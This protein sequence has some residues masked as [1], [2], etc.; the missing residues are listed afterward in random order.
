[1]RNS[2]RATLAAVA[3]TLSALAFVPA[4]AAD[5][6]WRDY[7]ALGDS[8]PAGIG[9]GGYVQ[10]S[11]GCLRSEKMTYAHH[12][13]SERQGTLINAAC[14]GATTEEI[15]PQ[16][17]FLNGGTD[18]VTVQV[19]GND[20][21]FSSVLGTCKTRGDADCDAA[22]G[23]AVAFV[24]NE[25]GPRL[26][27]TYQEVRAKA[28]NARVVVVGYPRLFELGSCANEMSE[29]KRSGLNAAV[30][31]LT[32]VTANRAAAAG[33]TFVDTRGVFA[34]HGVCGAQP[35]VHG[36]RDQ[37]VESYHPTADGG[38]LGYYPAVRAVL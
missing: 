8:H 33:F 7:V 10:D 32:E 31:Q 11:R 1:M 18:L 22:L 17:A 5:Q 21:G 2:V 36:L 27:G 23:A 37:L 4:A 9:A 38:R 25:L 15:A 30:D 20:A 6:S 29:H 34:G 13:A 24:R 16:M 14:S 12:I 26:D 3:A 28:P 35:W 19:G